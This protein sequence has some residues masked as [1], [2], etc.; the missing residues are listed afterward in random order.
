[1]LRQRFAPFRDA[2]GQVAFPPVQT[3]RNSIQAKTFGHSN[4]RLPT[5]IG[6]PMHGCATTT[7]SNPM[8]RFSKSRRAHLF[9]SLGALT[10]AALV[11]GG[12]TAAAPRVDESQLLSVGFKVLVATNKAQ[13]DW[14]RG[15]AP[16]QI[17]PM[18]RNGKKFF[19]YPDASRKQIYVGGPNEYDGVCA[20]PPREQ[21]GCR[22][23]G[24]EGQRVPLEAGRHDEEGDD[25]RPVGPVP[26]RQLGRFRLVGFRGATVSA[27]TPSRTISQYRSRHG[28]AHVE[29]ELRCRTD[30]RV[31]RGV[32]DPVGPA[33]TDRRARPGGR[34]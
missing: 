24:E 29:K 3:S 13:Q 12:A 22:R 31:A 11:A 21:G 23:C 34:V 15:L 33:R 9:R 28:F 26:G 4:S 32:A 25:S 20:A 14:V 18:Q 19:I 6:D 8:T 2:S 7:G 27:T 17:R 5:T 30:R 10:R 1:M 16:G